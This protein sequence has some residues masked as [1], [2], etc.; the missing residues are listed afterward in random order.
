MVDIEP[1]VEAADIETARKLFKEYEAWLGIDLGFQGFE[2]ELAELPGGYAPPLGCLLIAR[3]GGRVAG[4]VAMRCLGVDVC[5]MKRLFA[6]PQFRGQ[7]LGRALVERVVA[8]AREIG[9]KKMRLDTLPTMKEA[10][11]L[12]RSLGFVEIPPYRANPVEG[13]LYLELAL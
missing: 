6:R 4:C 7:G 13:T 8:D 9:Y 1:A 10:I 2:D 11:A 12:Y 3:V 5:E